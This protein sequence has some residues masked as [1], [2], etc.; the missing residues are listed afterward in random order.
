MPAG[1][2][3]QPSRSSPLDTNAISVPANEP[4]SPR[5]GNTA[6]RPERSFAI[7]TN[8]VGVVKHAR[9]WTRWRS[10]PPNGT[11]MWPCGRHRRPSA[12]GYAGCYVAG[13][14]R[15]YVQVFYRPTENRPFALE[16]TRAPGIQAA[17][18]WSEG[19]GGVGSRS[20]IG[21][22]QFAILFSTSL[23][24][25]CAGLAA[26]MDVPLHSTNRLPGRPMAAE[27]GSIM[28]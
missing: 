1:P 23:V 24:G 19:R 14:P 15:G 20:V 2:G 13:R 4:T 17:P 9:F 6:H 5:S 26:G 11:P 22:N 18:C 12:C 25:Q 10:D 16:G 7:L 28:I 3:T 8:G 21:E 27:C